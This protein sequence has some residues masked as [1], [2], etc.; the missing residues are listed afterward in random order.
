MVSQKLICMSRLYF[1]RENRRR[2]NLELT[3]G[4]KQYPDFA[5][6]TDVEVSRE[7]GLLID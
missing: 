7:K 3:E 2:D 6:I 4:K 5:D 1:K